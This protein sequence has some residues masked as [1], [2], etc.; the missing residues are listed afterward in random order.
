MA[1]DRMTVK[2][3]QMVCRG[4][5][6][7]PLAMLKML[8]PRNETMMPKRHDLHQIPVLAQKGAPSGLRGGLGKS[9]GAEFFPPA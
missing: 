8:A 6:G 7:T 5:N 9:I 3:I 4:R 1:W 2:L